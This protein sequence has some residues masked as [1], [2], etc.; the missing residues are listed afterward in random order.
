MI[1]KAALKKLEHIKKDHEKRLLDLKQEQDVDMN[2]AQLIEMNL[3]L[4]GISIYLIF[5]GFCIGKYGL[6]NFVTVHRYTKLFCS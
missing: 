1:E 3:D 5:F 6:K 4:V 2:K